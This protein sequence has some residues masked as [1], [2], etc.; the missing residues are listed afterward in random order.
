MN[1]LNLRASCTKYFINMDMLT[2]YGLCF[3]LVANDIHAN[4]NKFHSVPL[5]L[6]NKDVCLD[7]LYF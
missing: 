6:E 2:I 3:Q 4:V 5:T 7:V 1:N